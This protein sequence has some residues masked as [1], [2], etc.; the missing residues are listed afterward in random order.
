MTGV[1][2]PDTISSIGAEAYHG[3]SSLIRAVY[4]GSIPNLGTYAFDDVHSNFAHYARWGGSPGD[5]HPV[6]SFEVYQDGLVV[7]FGEIL[8]YVGMG[9]T[10]SIPVK[11]EDIYGISSVNQIH[12]HAFQ[13]CTTLAGVVIPA[14]VSVMAGAFEGCT[15]LTRAV[16]P[17]AGVVPT[18]RTPD[19]GSF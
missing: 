7:G 13:G 17:P 2:F 10:L 8:T 15:S 1:L 19:L 4:L 11:V 16:Y 5:G 9:G 18:I 14:T 12:E 3:C 6:N